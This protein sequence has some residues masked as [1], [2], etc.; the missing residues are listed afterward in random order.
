MRS[1][2]ADLLC[3]DEVRKQLRGTGKTIKHGLQ[4]IPLDNIV[5]SVARYDDFTRGFLPKRDT[6]EA[7]WTGVKVAIHDMV[8]IPP[9]DVY[10]VGDAYFV[11]DGNHRVSIARRLETKTI[12][13][14]VT[15]VETRVPMTA[16]DDPNEI[17]CKSY[18]ADFLVTT[19]LD[20][21]RPDADLLMTFCGQ[22]Q[23]LL[24][25][26]QAEL[27]LLEHEP[28]S[29]Q[30]SKLQEMA[31]TD[32]YDKV[33]F[34]VIQII[35][36]LGVL[37]RF[38]DKTE[39]DMYVLLSERRSEL[40][41]DF[42][43]NLEME[44][45]ISDLIDSGK[46]SHGLFERL[47]K[48]IVPSLDRGPDPGIWRRQQLARQRYHHLF[49]HILVPLDGSEEGWQMFEYILRAAQFD[50]DHILGLHVISHKD[51][52][53]SD[54]IYQMKD[55]FN[56]ECNAAS[57]QGEFAIEIGSSPVQSIIRHAAWVDFVIVNSK[58]PPEHQ[59]LSRISED[60]RLIIQKCPRPLQVRPN[61]T[62]S[63]YS[64]ALLAYDGSPKANEAL[65]I[66]TYL[67]ARWTKSLTVVTV[68]TTHTNISALESAQ[69]YLENHGITNVN[70]IL[71]KGP[72]AKTILDVAK[73]SD[74]NLL[75]M[76]GFS[77][78]PV[79]HLT[80]GSTAEQILRE[81]RH[82]MWVCR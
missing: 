3:F 81:F 2:T 9:I 34:P 51:Q 13:A 72:I 74:I 33:Y 54:P 42:G 46:K 57:I 48:R 18:Y 37:H 12:S 64:H 63:D 60:L 55:R 28:N 31:V 52:L 32:W 26:I 20:K 61:G 50:G 8:G 59:P 49:E 29:D 80:L 77:F 69:R 75:F 39:A 76:G 25:Q 5:G 67:T 41:K 70:Y 24:D 71:Q 30:D 6:D 4:E 27:I 43:W 35:R 44:S 65:F 1:S 16:E 66:A 79:R 23:V 40:E 56:K 7:R 62:Q 14:Y 22:Y 58:R 21:L 10:Q 36:E 19:N 45:G 73:N 38:P 53:D 11:Q 78:R 68:E 82:P 47:L 15:E 17:I